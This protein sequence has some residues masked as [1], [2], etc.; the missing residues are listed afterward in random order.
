[1]KIEDIQQLPENTPITVSWR[2]EVR[3]ATIA[4]GYNEKKGM[5]F[6]WLLNPKSGGKSWAMIKPEN[7]IGV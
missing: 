2:D 1:M 5:V 3:S 6:I 7:I 4:E